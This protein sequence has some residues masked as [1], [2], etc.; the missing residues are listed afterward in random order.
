MLKRTAPRLL[1]Y[2][3][4]C[5]LWAMPSSPSSQIPGWNSCSGNNHTMWGPCSIAK[6]VNITPITIWF[7]VFV[8]IVPG[9]YKPTN[10]SWGPHIVHIHRFRWSEVYL[11][12]QGW[13]LPFLS[14][15]PPRYCRVVLL[16]S[17]FSGCLDMRYSLKNI[18]IWQFDRM[19]TNQ[20]GFGH[21]R[22]TW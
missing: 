14:A 16:F 3:T 20:L 8:T 21:L 5:K 11:T 6:F 13:F 12:F 19:M 17:H 9:A 1:R 18:P 10:I 4:T 15:Q 22:T 2:V 7:M